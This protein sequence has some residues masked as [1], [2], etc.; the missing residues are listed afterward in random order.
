MVINAI[1]TNLI[2]YELR[3]ES[4]N[5][6][7]KFIF[8]SRGDSV[9]YDK[10]IYSTVHVQKCFRSRIFLERENKKK[11]Y[12]KI[13]DAGRREQVTIMDSVFQRNLWAKD[14]AR[15]I[16]FISV[17]SG[18]D[19]RKICP[20]GQILYYNQIV[21]IYACRAQYFISVCNYHI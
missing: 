11:D 3:E 2:S 20:R 4:L 12:Y 7:K 5:R 1:Q 9:S 14:V 8:N 15:N 6:C 21:F 18:R 13:S 17:K 10:G 19:A 16:V